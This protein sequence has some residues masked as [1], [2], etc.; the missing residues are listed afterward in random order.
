VAVGPISDEEAAGIATFGD[1]RKYTPA[2]ETLA[3]S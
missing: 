2:I 1:I 3:A